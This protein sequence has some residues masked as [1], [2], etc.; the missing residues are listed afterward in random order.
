MKKRTRLSA[1]E[2]RRIA[3]AAQGFGHARPTAPDARHLR[4]VVHSLGLLQL[5]FVNVLVPAHYLVL[6]SRLGAYDRR[7]LDALLWG[8]GEFTE[9]WAH[10]ASVIP[11]N[12]WPLL[13]YR[14]ETY[15]PW[16]QSPIMQLRG[17]E[18]YLRIVLEIVR[19][20]GPVTAGDV[21]PMPGPARRPG[22]WYRSVARSALEYH[23]GHGTIAVAGRLPNFQRLYDAP[24]R[25]IDRSLRLQAHAREDACRELLRR[26]A[27]AYGVATAGDLA[28]YWRMSPKEARPRIAELLEEGSLAEV[29]VEG[30][31]EPAFLD[32]GA[33]LPRAIQ[34]GTLLSPFDPL[35]WFRPRAERLFDFH[36]RLEIY[37]PASKRK[38]GYYVLPF[39]LDDR[40]AARVDLKADRRAGR[41]EV[42]AAYLEEGVDRRRCARELS[43]ALASLGEWLDLPGVNVRSR[44][45]FARLLAQALRGGG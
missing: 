18:E 38:W 6:W 1:S 21:P 25:V 32:A 35:V 33:R 13:A 4:R 31:R 7:R 14:R 45:G 37:V 44:A 10:E 12:T 19:A 23:F 3:L 30:W 8:S 5:D 17:R 29:A 9:H 43:R 27:R 24:E 34:A 20:R 22:D 39:L 42:Q 40:I 16:P 36:Y 2:A 11:A 26:A 28:D 15:R 41:L